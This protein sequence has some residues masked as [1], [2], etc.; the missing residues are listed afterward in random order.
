MHSGGLIF[1][2][3][4]LLLAHASQAIAKKNNSASGWD[5]TWSRLM[6]P[7]SGKCSRIVLIA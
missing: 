4:Q 6:M 2:H 5:K 1:K 3:L 7:K